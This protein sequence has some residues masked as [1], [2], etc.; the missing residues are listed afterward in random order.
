M[1]TVLFDP[2]YSSC[3]LG[4]SDNVEFLY[5][6]FQSSYIPHKQKKFQFSMLLPKIKET[7]KQNIAFYL[8]CLLWASYIKTV[9]G[10]EIIDNPCYEDE[11]NEEASIR[12]VKY[13]IDF[14]T[15][16]LNK[17]SK[18]YTG[19]PYEYDPK[20]LKI[21]ETYIEFIKMNNGFVNLKTTDELNLPSNIKPLNKDNSEI[22]KN[23]IDEAIKE[24]KLS[25]LYEVYD[26]IL[27]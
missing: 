26:L 25:K 8:G 3:V 5:G 4:I 14:I 7:A 20:H 10:A 18:Y 17:D 24:K 11:Y 2:G 13:L 1:E 16:I 21:L 23:K 27:D 15:D 19:K 12:D 6:T 9:K 22:V